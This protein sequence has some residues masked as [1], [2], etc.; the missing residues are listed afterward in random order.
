MCA[1]GNR[2]RH[3]D[4]PLG[5]ARLVCLGVDGWDEL[6]GVVKAS[7]VYRAVEVVARAVE[8]PETEELELPAAGSNEL[9]PGYHGIAFEPDAGQAWWEIERW[10]ANRLGRSECARQ[11]K[12][13]RTPGRV[14]NKVWTHGSQRLQ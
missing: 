7:G 13:Q 9:S 10:G 3:G 5:L 2:K 8:E 12:T 11:K 14:R 1:C 4:P 6:V